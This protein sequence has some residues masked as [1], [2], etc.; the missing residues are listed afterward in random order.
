MSGDDQD[1]VD[2][3]SDEF[4]D[5]TDPPGGRND[6]YG[7]ARTLSAER[8]RSD[9]SKPEKRAHHNALERKRRDH[10]KDSFSVLRDCIPTLVGD[11]ASRAMI[12]NRATDY[13]QF[14][15]KK[16]DVQEHE[17]DDLRRQNKSL[18]DQI[19]ALERETGTTP[20]D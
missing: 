18:A 9:G 2:V 8:D 10:I 13:I 4:D 11:K 14:M 3:E 12:L 7:L 15:R 16:N 20:H 5:T 1:D 6:S 17:V 19:K